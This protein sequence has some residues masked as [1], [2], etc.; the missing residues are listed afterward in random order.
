MPDIDKV[1]AEKIKETVRNIDPDADVSIFGSRARGSATDESDWD[2]IVLTSN[3]VTHDYKKTIR[4]ALYE[5]EWDNDCVIST[6]IH[7]HEEWQSP[8]MMM[9]PFYKNVIREA[10]LL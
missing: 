7:S 6:V 2:V 4:H 3:N 10:V 5:I 1:I 8:R 9:T